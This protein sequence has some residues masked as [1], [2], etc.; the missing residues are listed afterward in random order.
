M[1]MTVMLQHRQPLAV[2]IRGKI[3]L[4]R[5]YCEE[6]VLKVV[7]KKGRHVFIISDL[8]AGLWFEN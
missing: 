7:L 2:I 8:K 1:I 3:P 5:F 6:K 4:E